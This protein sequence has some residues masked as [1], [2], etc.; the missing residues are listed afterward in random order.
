MSDT[1]AF[2]VSEFSFAHVKSS[3]QLS[4]VFVEG[5]AGCYLTSFPAGHVIGDSAAS[6]SV[7]GDDNDNDHLCSQLR[8]QTNNCRV[9]RSLSVLQDMIQHVL[10]LLRRN[11][12]CATF[13]P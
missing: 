3:A 5:T 11:Q 2:N 9:C 13:V 7:P 4:S 1:P 12:T 6:L 8:V 10:K